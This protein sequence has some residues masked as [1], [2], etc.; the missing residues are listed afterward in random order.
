MRTSSAVGQHTTAGAP[1]GPP[2][3]S[4]AAPDPPTGSS[5]GPATPDEA[6]T[7]SPTRPRIGLSE[8]LGKYRRKSRTAFGLIVGS[9]PVDIGQG[10][11]VIAWERRAEW[12]LAGMAVAFL[13]AYSLQVLVLHPVAWQRSTFSAVVWITWLAFAADYVVRVAIAKRPAVYASR[14]WL[15]LLIIALPVLRPLRVLRVIMLVRAINRKAAGALR[16]RVVVYGAITASILIYC[17][18]LTVLEAERAHGNIKSFGDA[19]W[20]SVVTMTTVGYGDKFPISTQG[21]LVGVGL[22]VTGVGLF[23]AVT[24]SFATLLADQLRDEDAEEQAT[25]KREL[26]AVR[27]QLTRVERQLTTLQRTLTAR[28]RAPK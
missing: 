21:R 16:G 10:K 6:T 19:L 20:W 2:A 13:A 26:E 8:T 7:A 4:A 9:A 17:A 18:S 24:A 28:D 3:G 14:H 15:D 1:A 23:G 27:E 22:M 5:A 12:P 11:R 25:T